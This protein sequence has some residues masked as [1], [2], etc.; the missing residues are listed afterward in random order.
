MDLLTLTGRGLSMWQ[1]EGRIWY[2]HRALHCLTGQ[3]GWEMRMDLTLA[4]NTK[5]FLHYEQFKVASASE[6]YKLSVGDHF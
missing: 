4:D 2:G 6:K 5:V 3:G 1:F